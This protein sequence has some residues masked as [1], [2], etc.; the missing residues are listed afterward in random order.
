MVGQLVEVQWLQGGA[1][2]GGLASGMA[3]GT[4]VTRGMTG[5]KGFVTEI[6]GCEL[7]GGKKAMCLG[8]KGRDA[9]LAGH[10]KTLFEDEKGSVRVL[11]LVGDCVCRV[12]ARSKGFWGVSISS[13]SSGAQ[14]TLLDCWGKILDRLGWSCS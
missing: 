4:V 12:T 10:P 6:L 5:G 2:G 1:E 3:G 8:G 9:G 11:D 13:K 7:K 14:K